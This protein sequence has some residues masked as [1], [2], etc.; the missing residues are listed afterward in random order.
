[1][2]FPPVN[3]PAAE[4]EWDDGFDD[5]QL[6]IATGRGGFSAR[7]RLPRFVPFQPEQYTLHRDPWS[8]HSVVDML[9][10]YLPEISLSTGL[11]AIAGVLGGR[12][13]SRFSGGAEMLPVLAG[14]LCLH[15]LILA[16]SYVAAKGHPSARTR[17]RMRLIL[18]GCFLVLTSHLLAN[19]LLMAGA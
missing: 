13:F 12:L 1:M 2:P 4:L 19:G 3:G 15:A 17:A 14:Y 18:L 16:S 9:R 6:D 5:E 11:V 10:I 7:R 8:V